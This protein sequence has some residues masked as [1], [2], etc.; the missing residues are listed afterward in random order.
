MCGITGYI[1]RRPNPEALR[2]MTSRIAHRGPDGEGFHHQ[3]SGDWHIGFG[4]RR[5]AIIDI[6]GGAQPETDAS[7]RNVITYN[8][9][10]YNFRRLRA[11]LERKSVPFHTQCDT[12]VVLQQMVDQGQ[13]GVAA[14]DGMFAFAYWDDRHRSLLLARDRAGIKPLYYA[15]T[16]DG[17]II[18]ASELTALLEHPD[19]PRTVDRESVAWFFFSDYVPPPRS[20][21][22][23]VRKLEPGCSIQWDNGRLS[24][25]RR[26]W[27]PPV[28]STSVGDDESAIISIRDLLEEAVRD[29]M[30]ADV[31]LGVFLSGGLD[32]ST[33]ALFASRHTS[34]PLRTFSIGFDNPDFDESQYA[35]QVAEHIGS[36]HIE[37]RI[38]EADLLDWL[39]HALAA[40]DEPMADPSIVPTYLVS[41]VAA[42][43]V[44]VC[45]GGDGGDELFGGYP[46]LKAHRL[47][48]LYERVPNA[49]QRF[50]QHR[51]LPSLPNSD[52]RHNFV[53]KLERFASRFENDAQR[54][55]LRWMGNVDLPQL[56]ELGI[57]P[58]LQ[59]RLE[60][61]LVRPSDD[62]LN[63]IIRLDFTTYLPHSVLTKVDRA[64]MAQA[65][66]ARPP[67]LHTR[68]M[69]AALALP[70]C[71]K[72]RGKTGKWVLKAAVRGELPNEIIDRPKRGFGIPLQGWMRGA[73]AQRLQDIL[74]RS[75]VWEHELLSQRRFREYFDEHQARR[76]DRAKPLWSLLVLDDW[77]RRSLG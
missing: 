12:E 21:L 5:L 53:W 48:K 34:T 59:P 43:H 29:Q 10:V 11:V 51:L 57:E 30:V 20:I 35:R 14:L 19:C 69:D 49:L 73:L 40:I 64:S 75:P 16:P 61:L 70:S 50:V 66:E 38:K 47:A 33:I 26:Y 2:R 22:K 71:M 68:L 72:Y 28:T 54:R 41:R 46:T 63:D 36:V 76:R 55:H 32:S 24:E 45:L 8:G 1:V 67:F 60:E 4:H 56:P 25:P 74:S 39:P 44:K 17:G 9:E 27:S 58:A 77:M 62:L 52:R 6:A 7:G 37:E 3:V 65:L 13:E 18:F 23:G 15:S 31:P 42:K